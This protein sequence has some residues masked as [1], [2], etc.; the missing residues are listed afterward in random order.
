M[1]S[2]LVRQFRRFWILWSIF[3]NLLTWSLYAMLKRWQ[4]HNER[5][6][7]EQT[8]S[9]CCKTYLLLFFF[10]V[11]FLFRSGV[12][13]VLFSTQLSWLR[14][15]HALFSGVNPFLVTH[16]CASPSYYII[17]I[18]MYAKICQIISKVYCHAHFQ[19]FD[20]MALSWG[21]CLDSFI[22]RTLKLL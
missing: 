22:G 10:V 14:L 16:D 1:T 20:Y 9:K 19:T 5:F 4:R 3:E 13:R 11:Y 21:F 8:C 12:A 18:H 17:V 15:D 7:C 2:I 6:Y